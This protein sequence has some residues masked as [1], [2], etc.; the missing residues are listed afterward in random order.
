MKKVVIL[1][2]ILLAACNGDSVTSPDIPEVSLNKSA[3]TSTN[4]NPIMFNG[5]R[6]ITNGLN[7]YS[8]Y[9]S[10]KT[11]YKNGPLPSQK[12]HSSANDNTIIGHFLRNLGGSPW[13][14]ILNTYNDNRGVKIP[15]RLTYTGWW[16]NNVNVPQPG[17]KVFISDIAKMLETSFNNKTL[18]YNPN[19]IYTVFTDSGVNLGGEFGTS[20]CA[21]HTAVNI[22]IG[23]SFSP[24]LI[25]G[26]PYVWQEPWRCTA[27]FRMPS[28]NNQPDADGAVNV[29]AHEIAESAT[30]GFGRAWYDRNQLEVGDKCAWNFGVNRYVAGGS[31]T[32]NA[33]M[34]LNGV[35]YLVQT[36]WLNSRGGNGGCVLRN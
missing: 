8:I 19:T 15:N 11:I 6:V 3:S 7:I 21:F 31:S 23:N 9:W 25:V 24:V 5:G 32:P 20:Y 1:G 10:S 12:S 33:N 29:L 14:N 34:N 22:K 36:L 16:A 13:F 4:A 30:N 28:P 26:I 18:T 17:S 35:H 2:A 27:F